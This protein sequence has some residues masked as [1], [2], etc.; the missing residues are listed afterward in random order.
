MKATAQA[1]IKGDTSRW[2]VIREGIKTKAQELLASDE[3]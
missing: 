3:E 1:L 2:G